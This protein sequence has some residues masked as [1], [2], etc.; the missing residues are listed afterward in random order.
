MEIYLVGGAVRDKLLGRPIEERDYVVV[1]TTPENLLAQ[2]YRPVGKDFPVFLHPHT[3]EE[4]ALARTERKIGPGY[5]GFKVY[6]APDVTLEEDL[7]RRDL[8]IN[9]IAQTFDGTLIDPFGGQRDLEQGILR[10]VSPA[11]AE[12]PVR[13]LRVARFAAR[14]GFDVAPETLTLMKQM[15]AAGEV[16]YLV[17]ERVWKELEQALA[18]LYPRRFFEMLRAC[19]ALARIFPEI[20]RLFGVPQ[21]KRYHPE[22]DTGIHTLKVLEIASQLSQDTQVRFAA[23]THDLGKGETPAN[24][25][26]H[27]YGHGE[28]GVALVLALCERLRIP[29]SY[30]DLAVHVAHYHNQAHLAQE[31]R[32]GTLLK[33]LNSVDAFRR[34]HRFEQFLLACE[35]DARGRA[36]LEDRLY[37]QAHWLRSAFHA[38]AAVTA[39]P[40]VAAGLQGKAIA[41]E[42]QQRRIATI[43]HLKARN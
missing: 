26:P 19:G 16:D 31:L 6:A 28:R 3:Q 41:Q 14:F 11:F 17:P 37:P 7:Q 23:L 36:G 15:T 2:G 43:K 20:E 13:I 24:E 18:E 32:P 40:L 27:H 38:A 34:P 1:G 25:W 22:I 29:K 21:P 42:L 8:T 5:K 35:A 39:Q 12:D 33:L 30:C 9:A 10:H 4:Y